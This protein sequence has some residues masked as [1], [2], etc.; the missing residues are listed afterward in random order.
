MSLE[1]ICQVKSVI[2][3]KKLRALM[4]RNDCQAWL[5]LLGHFTFIFTTGYLVYLSMHTYWFVPAMFLHGIGIV[6]LFSPQHEFAHRTAFRTRWLNDCFGWMMGLLIMLPNVYFRWEHT[7]HH[8]YTQDTRRDPQRIP[9]PDNLLA[10]IFYLSSLVYWWGFL[11]TFV[12]HLCGHINS[13]KESFI[14]WTERWKVIAEAWVMLVIYSLVAVYTMAYDS[15]APL[16]YWLFPRLLAE[17]Y[18]RFVRMAEHVGRPVNNQDLLANTRTT[19]VNPLLRYLAW[20]MPYHA[21]HHLCP[22]IP[23]HALPEFHAEI[24][25]KLVDVAKGYLEAHSDIINKT[26]HRFDPEPRQL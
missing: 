21:E 22:A 5:F 10:Y 9:Q 8:S 19:K 17:P 16:Y 24:E 4:H 2:A 11:K 18:M 14:P 3:R 23:F 15:Y 20:N 26:M 6:H 12:L 7:A 25:D 13:Q 1:H